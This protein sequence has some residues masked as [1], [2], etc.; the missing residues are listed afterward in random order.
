MLLRTE[1]L[2]PLSRAS[3]L[4]MLFT[5]LK[6]MIQH[7][8]DMPQQAIHP[9]LKWHLVFKVLAM[10]KQTPAVLLPHRS[11]G[12]RKREGVTEAIRSDL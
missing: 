11:R 2:E 10:V 1:L 5:L 8:P 3:L 6:N 7:A 4:E 12:V 9:V